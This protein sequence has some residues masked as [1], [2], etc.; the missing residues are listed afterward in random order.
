MTFSHMPKLREVRL[1]LQSQRREDQL[2]LIRNAVCDAVRYY[3][4]AHLGEYSVREDIR[5][6]F[7]FMRQRLECD[8]A[9][10]ESAAMD[11]QTHAYRHADM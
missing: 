6:A 4:N 5:S 11:L 10:V 9:C 8:G 1:A 3:P 7:L 2:Y